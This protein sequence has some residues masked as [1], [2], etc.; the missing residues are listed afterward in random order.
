MAGYW[1]QY[2]GK[3]RGV[4][5]AVAILCVCLM[6][7][8]ATAQVAHSHSAAQG[9]DHCQ[10]CMAIHAPLPAASAATQ[11]ILEFAGDP[12]S[13]RTPAVPMQGWTALL[14]DRAPPVVA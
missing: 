2:G 14:S 13:I 7:L 8:A 9:P 11:L 10:I 5:R 6:M 1:L 3:R 12:I 4:I